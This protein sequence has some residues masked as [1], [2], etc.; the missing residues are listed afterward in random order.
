[1]LACGVV[2]IMWEGNYVHDW[3]NEGVCLDGQ[4]KGHSRHAHLSLS[5]THMRTHTHTHTHTHTQSKCWVATVRTGWIAFFFF[6]ESHVR[7]KVARSAE[8]KSGLAVK[9][10]IFVQCPFS[11][12][13]LKTCSYE[14]IFVLSRASKQLDGV[15]FETEVLK[16][17]G[18][19]HT[20]LNSV[21]FSEVRK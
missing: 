15:E 11:Y 16:A 6:R 20:I 13:W 18:N 3:M 5:H 14:L 1:M 4:G 8:S 2:C 10:Q 19:F 17:K 9:S 12:F 7:M 21:L